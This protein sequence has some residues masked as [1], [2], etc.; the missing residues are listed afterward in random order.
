MFSQLGD[1]IIQQRMTRQYT[2]YSQPLIHYMSSYVVKT[3]LYKNTTCNED[4]VKSSKGYNYG[5]ILFWKCSLFHLC[6]KKS[7]CA[8]ISEWYAC[9]MHW[10][11]QEMIHN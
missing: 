2:H 5:S 9:H 6:L 11:L 10:N 7:S 4:I 3:K 1:V 8:Y